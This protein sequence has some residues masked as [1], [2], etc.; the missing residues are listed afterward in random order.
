MFTQVAS[1]AAQQA[2]PLQGVV[3]DQAEWTPVAGA[4][5][6][7][8]GTEIQTESLANGTFAFETA[9]FG[10]VSVRVDAPGYTS[11]VQEVEVREGRVAFVQFLLPSLGA[12]LDEILVVGP[13][14]ARVPQI[15][16]PR[17]AADLLA[18]KIPGVLSNPGEVGIQSSRMRV[19]GVSSLTV[20]RDPVVYLDGV[21]LT[22]GFRE[23]LARLRQIPAS[24]VRHIEV[25]RGPAAAFLQG[26]ADGAIR[27]WT[28][29]GPE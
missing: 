25:L 14:P 2:A 26:S 13:R 4:R 27:V 23:A 3:V 7:L 22:G 29:Q 12:V 9:P 28:R 15:A 20:V 21:R 8:V 17:T 1:G 18:G 16:E 19:R 11:I 10:T 6:T 5:L 24:D